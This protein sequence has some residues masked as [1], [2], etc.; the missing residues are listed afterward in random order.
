TVVG[1]LRT[2]S[3][4]EVWFGEKIKPQRRVVK[5][6]PGCWAGCEAKPNAIYT[7][8]FVKAFWLGS[9]KDS[10]KSENAEERAAVK[11]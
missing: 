1:N 11:A 6:C 8:D 4:N 5:N 2:Q 10:M 7:G 9:L 3:L